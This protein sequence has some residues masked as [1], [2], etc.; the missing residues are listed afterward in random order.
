MVVAPPGEPEAASVDDAEAAL[1]EALTR[2]PMAK[3]VSEVAK[4]LGVDRKEL[5]ARALEMKG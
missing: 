2:L 5:Y 3:A 1:T 4:K